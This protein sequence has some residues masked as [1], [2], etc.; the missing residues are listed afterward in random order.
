MHYENETIE[1]IFMDL[2]D[3]IDKSIEHMK[4]E[5]SLLRAGRAN[6]KLIEKITVDYYGAPTPIN[7]MANIANPEARLL[8]ISV[9]DKSMLSKVE[10]AILAS[11]V[12]VTPQNDGVVIRMVFPELNQE[13]RQELVKTV[14]KL[15]EEAK[16]SIRNIRRDCLESL[17][18]VKNEKTISED[19]ISVYEQEV[20]KIIT[21]QIEVVDKLSKEKET[22]ILTI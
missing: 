11:N 20:D 14:R 5:Y 9:W 12:G 1:L 2:E 15:G 13:R 18:K 21:K 8:V 4:N 17:K 3:R 16:V 7:Q 10:K 6:P 22:E 19:S